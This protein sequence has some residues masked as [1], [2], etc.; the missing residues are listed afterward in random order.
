[1]SAWPEAVWLKQQIANLLEIKDLEQQIG[2]LEITAKQLSQE[3]NDFVN[4][5]F[6]TTIIPEDNFQSFTIYNY[7]EGEQQEIDLKNDI[8]KVN[9]AT[10]FL[11]NDT[12][13]EADTDINKSLRIKLKKGIPVYNLAHTVW[14][15]AT[16]SEEKPTLFEGQY[17]INFTIGE[18]EKNYQLL[19]FYVNHFAEIEQITQIRA[20]DS[21]YS[22][23]VLYDVNEGWKKEDF[24]LSTISITGGFKATDKDLISWFCL[25]GGLKEE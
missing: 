6:F 4:N 8:I 19:N 3:I 7:I 21:N 11:T 5:E 17:L 1:M 12:P 13:S 22:Y 23:D 2:E 25:N 14:F 15:L 18:E 9:A 24:D 16:E 10:V 20:M